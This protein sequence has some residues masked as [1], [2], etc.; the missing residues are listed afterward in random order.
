MTHPAYFVAL[1]EHRDKTVRQLGDL[2]RT[3]P[4]K[5]VGTVHISELCSM[6]DYPNGLYLLY[7]DSDELWYV[8]KATSRSFVERIP[9][10][11]DQRPDAWFNALPKRIHD[12]KI[13]SSYADAHSLGLS[14]R[15][16]LVGVRN[17]TAAMKLE[18]VLRG[19]LQP[20]LNGIA[21]AGYTGN[22]PLSAYE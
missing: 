14:L 21:N 15:L 1:E 2:L 10:H 19:A 17:K 3:L 20:Q 12:R 8:G 22:E 5:A 9:A 16:A 13:T 18:R 6:K 4:K 7:D 11:F